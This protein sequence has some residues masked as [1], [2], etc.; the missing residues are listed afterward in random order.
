MSSCRDKIAQQAS[1]HEKG[2]CAALEDCGSED[3]EG[4]VVGLVV[5]VGGEPAGPHDRA[6]HRC[7]LRLPLVLR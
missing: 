1:L 2:A 4:L 6:S 7:H 5:V 3:G